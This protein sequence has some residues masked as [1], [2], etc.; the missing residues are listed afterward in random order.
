M[1]SGLAQTYHFSGFRD[2]SLANSYSTVQITEQLGIGTQPRLFN[3]TDVIITLNTD[4][5]SQ[6][7]VVQLPAT[8][9]YHEHNANTLTQYSTV[10]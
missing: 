1:N 7:E 2:R 3:A 5:L 9:Q 10:V 6:R 4:L 8:S